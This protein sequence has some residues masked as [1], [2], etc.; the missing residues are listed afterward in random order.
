MHEGVGK[1]NTYIRQCNPLW[2][3]AFL[4]PEGCSARRSL[5]LF[6]PLSLAALSCLSC[7]GQPHQSPALVKHRGR[8]WA[9]GDNESCRT[10]LPVNI[11]S[12]ILVALTLL[13]WLSDALLSAVIGQVYTVMHY[14]LICAKKQTWHGLWGI[15]WL[16][17]YKFA[18]VDMHIVLEWSETDTEG[19]KV[20]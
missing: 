5:S 7:T 12:E 17:C 16:N 8:R 10:S 2:T 19:K 6:V 18:Q 15:T 14:A 4:H 1:I 13:F 20:Q 11:T 9:G 3:P